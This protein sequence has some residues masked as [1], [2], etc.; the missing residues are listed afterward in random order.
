M[1]YAII[2]SG[3]VVNI[4]VATPEYAEQQG[5]VE[6]PQG[7][8]I[9]WTFDGENAIPP[10]RDIEGEWDVV[11]EKRNQLLTESDVMVMPDRWNAMTSEE[12]TAWAVYRQELRDIPQTYDDPADVV[13]PDKP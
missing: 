13:F 4:A 3:K 5:W 6:L 9:G 2:E 1:R 12:Q 7:V 11:R 10:P 8:G